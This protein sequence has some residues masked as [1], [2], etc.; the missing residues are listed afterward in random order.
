[1]R[2]GGDGAEEEMEDVH[3]SQENREGMIYDPD[4]TTEEKRKLRAK[5]RQILNHQEE[6]RTDMANIRIGDLLDSQRRAD[7][8]FKDVKAPQEATLD[9]KVMLQNAEMGAAM[10]R[11]MK[12]DASSFDVD[13]YIAELV[14]YMGGSAGDEREDADEL[15]DDTQQLNWRKIG[16]R[17]YLYSH[18]APAMDFMLG[19]LAIEAKERKKTTRARL[20]KNKRDE[21]QPQELRPEDVQRSEN[22]TTKMVRLVSQKLHEVDE[23]GVNFFEFV[24]DPESYAQSI[25]NIFYVSFLVRDGR[26]AVFPNEETGLL[27]LYASEAPTEE[28]RGDEQKKQTVFKL[29][30]DVWREARDLFNLKK[31]KY[32]PHRT[33]PDDFDQ[34]IKDDRFLV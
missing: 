17:A 21:V 34:E 8:Y 14:S 22:E 3:E 23:N 4:Q 33:R 32:I 19:P 31:S 24:I 18:K 2:Q 16:T 13:E 5:Y 26:A 15:I 6:Q 11:A 28:E 7:A 30:A 25:E 29:T 12:H 9:S 27:T 1:M 10:A 20:Q